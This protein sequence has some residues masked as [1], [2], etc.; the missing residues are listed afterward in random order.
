MHASNLS[1]TMAI[2]FICTDV[3]IL[4]LGTGNPVGDS[5]K[6]DELDETYNLEAPVRAELPSFW[7]VGQ[8]ALRLQ[9]A[10]GVPR[11]K[12][13]SKESFYGTRAGEERADNGFK[14]KFCWCPPGRF[15]MGTPPNDRTSL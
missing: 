15:L 6:T 11:I 12:L 5:R 3:A 13:R 4:A 8:S 14:L 1:T 7:N 10:L 2:F 9:I